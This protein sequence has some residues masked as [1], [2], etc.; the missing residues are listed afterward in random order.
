MS[1]IRVTSLPSHCVHEVNGH[2]SDVD[3]K[4]MFYIAC[5]FFDYVPPNSADLVTLL[6]AFA[7]FFCEYN[8]IYANVLHITLYSIHDT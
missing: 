3:N 8:K 7:I 6:I 2:S 5:R 4:S 1:A